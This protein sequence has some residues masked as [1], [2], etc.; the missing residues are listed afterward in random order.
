MARHDLEEATGIVREIYRLDP[1]FDIPGTGL[2]PT[3][4]RRLGFRPV[5]LLLRVRRQL[6]WPLEVLRR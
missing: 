1:A 6:V 4:Y 5:S 2:L 3:L